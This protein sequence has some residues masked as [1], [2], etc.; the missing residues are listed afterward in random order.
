MPLVRST[1]T[2]MPTPMS[3]ESTATTRSWSTPM[4][5]SNASPNAVA[6]TPTTTTNTTWPS[7][8][9]MAVASAVRPMPA[10]GGMIVMARAN[11]TICEVL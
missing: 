1:S 8:R 10:A 2:T 3:T 4:V 7:R 9:S 5:R 6:S 11:R